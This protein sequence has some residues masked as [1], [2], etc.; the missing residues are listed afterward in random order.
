VRPDLGRSAKGA[1]ALA[2]S[3]EQDRVVVPRADRPVVAP[4]GE[5]RGRAAGASANG[6]P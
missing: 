2:D 3:L 6:F 1:T 5:P 4:H